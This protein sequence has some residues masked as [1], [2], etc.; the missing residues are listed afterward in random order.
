MSEHKTQ[1]RRE[2]MP[3]SH[4]AGDPDFAHPDGNNPAWK[5][6]EQYVPDVV[7]RGIVSGIGS[8]VMGEDGQRGGI[9]DLK[10]PKEVVAHL[11]NQIERTKREV[12]L[13]LARELRSFLNDVDVIGVLQRVLEGMTIDLHTQVKFLPAEGKGKPKIQVSTMKAGVHSGDEIDNGKQDDS[14][15]NAQGKPQEKQ[16]SQDRPKTGTTASSAQGSAAQGKSKSNADDVT[17]PPARKK[18]GRSK[19]PKRATP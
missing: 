11:V 9:S 5:R 2:Q 10:L 16:P 13:A 17:S 6:F 18:P 15:R 14:Q 1:P 12:T 7:K 19:K 3:G 4:T 8:L